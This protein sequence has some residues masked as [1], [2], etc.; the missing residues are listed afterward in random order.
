MSQDKNI[1]F[2]TFLFFSLLFCNCKR[3]DNFNSDDLIDER[4]GQ[5]YSTVIL[6]NKKWMA[7]NLNYDLPGSFRNPDNPYADY[8]KLYNFQQAKVACPP[9][10][11]LPAEAEWIDLEK[12]IG[13]SGQGLYSI[14]YRGG[15]IG[16][17]LKSETGWI[18]SNG[19]NSLHFNA[20]P[21][22]LYDFTINAYTELGF[23][24]KF[25]SA[26]DSTSELTWIR[27]IYSTLNGSYRDVENPQNGL[28]CRCV[29]D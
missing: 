21:A 26:S 27:G 7:Q 13:L 10:W 23:K 16:F 14:G 8:G 3:A 17:Y 6:A 2:F 24:C 5:R 11:H 15:N 9:G 18:M 4:D 22:G 12:S 28:S 20:Y 25:W 19:K 29:E 1:Y